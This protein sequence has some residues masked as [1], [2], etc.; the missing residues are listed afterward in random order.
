MRKPTTAQFPNGVTLS[1]SPLGGH[2][3]NWDGTF[4]GWI[5]ESG[6][7]WNAFLR[8]KKGEPGTPLGRFPEDEAVR[9]IAIASGWPGVK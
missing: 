4:I 7:H 9:Q 6:D 3:V 8:G 1:R 5:H 2:T